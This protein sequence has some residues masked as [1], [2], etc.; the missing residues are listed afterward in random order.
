MT[1]WLDLGKI[2]VSLPKLSTAPENR[3]MKQQSFGHSGFDLTP[4][5]TC[6]WVFLD[7]MEP[8]IPWLPL[9][10]WVAQYTP[11]GKTGQM[12]SWN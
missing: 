4:K 10:T 6:K 7:E 3:R 9:V 2:C 1:I 11:E 8:V 12:A 5:K